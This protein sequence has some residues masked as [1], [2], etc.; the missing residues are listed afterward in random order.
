MPNKFMST[1]SDWLWSKVTGVDLATVQAQS[2]AA[3]AQL[4]QINNADYAPG[5]KIYDQVA[6]DQGTQAA[7][8]NWQ[9][10]QNDLQ[11]S[12]ATTANAADQVS[13][14]FQTQLSSE[15]SGISGVLSGS[16]STI[17][18]NIFNIIPWQVWI[19]AGLAL[20]IWL[21]GIN[22]LHGVIKKKS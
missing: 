15:T 5:G 14:A 12:A 1:I 8:K 20:F 16:I 9:T 10:V 18:K 3:D 6:T 19:V 21:G 17:L 13:G 2:D 4:Q 7:N 11:T 22:L